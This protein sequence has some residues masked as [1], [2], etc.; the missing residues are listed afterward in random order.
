[1]RPRSS[2]GLAAQ[3]GC[4]ASAAAIA[5][6]TSSSDERATRLIDSPVA[7]ASFS[8]V[9]PPEAARSLP[10]ITFST[11]RTSAVTVMQ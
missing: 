9:P 11:V 10:P 2:T 3:S 7:G 1:M 6:A 5:A 8:N 4:A